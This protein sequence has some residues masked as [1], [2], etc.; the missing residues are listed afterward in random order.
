[1]WDEQFI[2]KHNA[3]NFVNFLNYLE[4]QS[5][6]ITW[7]SKLSS[8]SNDTNKINDRFSL[9]V[10][11]NDFILSRAIS[12]NIKKNDYLKAILLIGKLIGNKEL[13]YLNLTTFQEIDIHLRALGFLNLRDEFRNE[14]L[15]KKF[16][17]SKNL[18]NE[19]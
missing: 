5:P 10:S 1:M 16:F 11:H 9:N 18:F 17:Y 4:M 19:F 3:W 2:S 8:T 12:D 15:Y 14:V 13:K 6:K 7:E